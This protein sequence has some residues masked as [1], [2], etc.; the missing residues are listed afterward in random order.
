MTFL[1]QIVTASESSGNGPRR[2]F[3]FLG[4]IDTHFFEGFVEV[5]N[6]QWFTKNFKVYFL[7]HQN[8]LYRKP[9]AIFLAWELLKMGIY[10]NAVPMSCIDNE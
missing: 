4:S 5:P 2:R 1:S 9:E 7:V 3:V 6:R 8:V 10:S